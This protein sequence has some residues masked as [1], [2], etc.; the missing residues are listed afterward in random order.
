M[1]QALQ[2]DDAS[3]PA[4]PR[5]RKVAVGAPIGWLRLGARD[6]RR[7]LAPSLFVG[8]LVAAGGW[9]LLATVW[10]LAALAP[11][12]L[13][14]FLYVAPFAAVLVYGYSR[15]LEGPPPPD[16]ARARRAWR[17]NW[18]S[19]AL[20][21]LVLATA[22]IFWERVAAVLFAA[23]YR[24]EPLRMANLF[25]SLV[26]SGDHVPLLAAFFLAGALLAGAVFALGVVS[27]PLLL[28][29]PVDVVTAAL[30]SVRCCLRNPA[31]MALWALLIA[32]ITWAGLLTLMLGLV[33]VFPWLAHASWHAYRAMVD[34]GS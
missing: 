9:L 28:D 33:V 27:V 3:P 8:A 30:T 21:G 22:L 16:W 19:I 14:G 11:A 20:F 29:R 23:F 1:E 2:H 31:A 32:L 12:L 13:G 7:S 15:E 34:A 5:V 18:R 4:P 6:L 24:G 26:L 10:Q 17:A 25:A